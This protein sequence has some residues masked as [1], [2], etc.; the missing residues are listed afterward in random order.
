MKL[1]KKTIRRFVVGFFIGMI[2]LLTTELV[3]KKISQHLAEAS[4][5][6]FSE[7]LEKAGVNPTISH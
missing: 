1:S 2:L 5:K 3:M 4:N 7:A 6:A